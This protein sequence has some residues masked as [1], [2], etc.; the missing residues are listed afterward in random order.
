MEVLVTN[1]KQLIQETRLSLMKP[2]DPSSY[3]TNGAWA[4]TP[5]VHGHVSMHCGHSEEMVL[6]KLVKVEEGFLELRHRGGVATWILRNELG[7]PWEKNSG[8]EG[9][10]FQGRQ[11]HKAGMWTMY[12]GYRR[13]P[14]DQCKLYLLLYR[15]HKFPQSQNTIID[16]INQATCQAIE[17][18]KDCALFLQWRDVLWES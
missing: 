14:T 11:R 7:F 12:S 10:L 1:L 16:L 3:S 4:S 8:F 5:K 13:G 15:Y 17:L 9:S 6:V 18:Y 2:Q